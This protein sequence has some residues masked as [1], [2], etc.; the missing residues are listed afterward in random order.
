MSEGYEEQDASLFVS[1]G[2]DMI[3]VDACNTGSASDNDVDQTLITRWSDVLAALTNNN[4][5][6]VDTTSTSLKSRSSMRSTSSSRSSTAPAPAAAARTVL[7]S[8]CRNGC[9]S[10]NET[11][12]AAWEPWCGETVSRCGELMSWCGEVVSWYGEV[13]SWCGEVVSWC[14]E[15]M[16]WCGEVVSWCGEVVSCRRH[17]LLLLLS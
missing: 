2:I 10:D 17:L 8:N 7:L 6:T 16:S 1:W 14:G 9:L 5:A 4:T 3:K 15:L 12:H 13:V 11:T